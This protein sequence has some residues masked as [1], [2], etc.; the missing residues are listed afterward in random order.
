MLKY[1]CIPES[2]RT[3]VLSGKIGAGVVPEPNNTDEG[4]RIL[5]SPRASL[6]RL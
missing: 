1:F 6:S 5:A 3:F 2:L 4:C